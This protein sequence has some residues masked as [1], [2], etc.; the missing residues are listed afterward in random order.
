MII[1]VFHNLLLRY[2]YYTFF[3]FAPSVNA[4]VKVFKTFL[5]CPTICKTISGLEF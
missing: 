1:S 5:K 3:L 2:F 4:L